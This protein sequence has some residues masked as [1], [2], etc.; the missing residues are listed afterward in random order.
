M[1]HSPY[2]RSFAIIDGSTNP[3]IQPL[4]VNN[5]TY[6]SDFWYTA[7]VE[8]VGDRVTAFMNGA[9]MGRVNNM[10]ED[11]ITNKSPFPIDV[12]AG[13]GSGVVYF[14]DIIVIKPAP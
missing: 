3:W 13:P 4:Q 9:S 5:Y 1:S 7:R 6:R 14:D 10:R 11:P 8:A 12:H 2:W